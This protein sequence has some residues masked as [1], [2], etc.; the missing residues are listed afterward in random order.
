LESE[1]GEDG[2]LEGECGRTVDWRVKVGGWW[3]GG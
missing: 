1:G 2:G 3:I